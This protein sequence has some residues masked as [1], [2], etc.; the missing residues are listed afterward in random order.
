MSDRQGQRCGGSH[1][2][3]VLIPILLIVALGLLIVGLVVSS[4]PLVVGCFVLS[5]VSFLLMMRTRARIISRAPKFVRPET[6]IV[7]ED[8]DTVFPEPEV[9]TWTTT[10]PVVRAEARIDP[11][12]LGK[13]D[14]PAVEVPVDEEPSRQVPAADGRRE[15]LVVPPSDPIS[16]DDLAAADMVSEGDPLVDEPPRRPRHAAPHTQAD[17]TEPAEP[18]TS[19]EPVIDA[20]QV[21]DQPATEVH[22]VHAP[23]YEAA[24]VDEPSMAFTVPPLSTHGASTVWVVD[25]HPRYHVQ[26]CAYL[27]AQ[28]A[29]LDIPL[30]QAVEDG[31]TPCALCNP[32]EALAGS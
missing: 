3:S 5:V 1:G 11:A 23:L 17:S 18:G 26:G 19:A 32:D 29:T 30:I 4:L 6:Q 20:E 15:T 28:D 24:P 10:E 27:A 12:S 9:R 7:P 14:G 22:E 2:V 31:F 8:L 13:D 21:V 25:E 16:D